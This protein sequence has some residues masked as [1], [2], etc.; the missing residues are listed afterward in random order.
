LR[1]A[2]TRRQFL[3]RGAQCA[4]GV[5]AGA[6][7]PGTLGDPGAPASEARPNVLLI[8][9]DD[10]RPALGCYGARHVI[11]PNID[12][13]ASRG[14]LFERAYCQQ[15]D[16]AASRASALSGARPDTTGVRDLSATLQQKMPGVL[17][18]PQHFRSH[19]YHTISLGKV[20]QHRG[21]DDPDGW[22]EEEWAPGGM[23]PG[24]GFDSSRPWQSLLWEE[25]SRPQPR[26]RIAGPPVEAADLPDEAYPDGRVASRAVAELHRL[27]ERRF[28]LAV[29]FARPHLAFACPAKYWDLYPP[30]SIRLAERPFPP[31]G[32]PEVAL[33]DSWELRSYRGV[34]EAGP[35]GDHLARRL[36]R[37]Y[38]ASVTFVDAQVGRVLDAL[39]RFGLRDRT[40]VVL[41]GDHGWSLGEHGLWGKN[42]CFEVALRA[43]LIVALPRGGGA[44]RSTRA[45]VELV[46]I[47]PSLCEF[48]GLP[49]PEH[50]EGTSFVPLLG[51]PDRPW[52]AA[53]FG[54]CPRASVMGHT[55]RTDRYRYTE[56]RRGA[57]APLTVELY[58]HA[59]DPGENVSVAG[60]EDRADVLQRMGGV[61]R[62]GWSAARPPAGAGQG[63]PAQE[64]A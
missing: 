55:V 61:F 22:S 2:L 18:L 58:D 54:Q 3:A 63:S 44:G 36:I 20:Y 57:G 38:S 47:F 24:Y 7:L 12:A 30:G 34:P 19:G 5:I 11:S 64:A 1:I 33:V 48:C 21:R 41:C 39:V 29:G 53:A 28:L 23:V 45:L 52:K 37:G 32:A 42:S 43:P 51:D 16:C 13:L 8:L 31:E 60:V 27:R 9:V 56:W 59:E 17:T 49:T 46:D 62:A 35:V 6:A 10:L 26:W 4:A 14:L 50:L 40:V 15:A 25:E